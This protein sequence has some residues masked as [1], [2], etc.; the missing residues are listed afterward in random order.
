MSTGP[1]SSNVCVL[2]ALLRKR[3]EVEHRAPVER[4]HPPIRMMRRAA[5]GVSIGHM[6]RWMA[7]HGQPLLVEELLFKSDHG[8]IEQSLHSRLCAE[9][10]N[11]DVFGIGG[12]GPGDGPGLFHSVS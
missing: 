4:A 9:T 8:L 3:V 1:S 7:W 12:Y 10:T 6:C 11:G 5:T 2:I